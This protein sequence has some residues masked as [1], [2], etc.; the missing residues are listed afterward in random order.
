MAE[1][2]PVAFLPVKR[3]RTSRDTTDLEACLFCQEKHG[4][5]CQASL[6]GIEKVKT[7]YETRKQCQDKSSKDILERM[8]IIVNDLEALRPKWHSESCYL[9]RQK[10]QIR[11]NGLIGYIHFY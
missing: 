9:L 4:N 2:K 8:E 6:A 1:M 5:L 3:R 7:A 11:K 10:L